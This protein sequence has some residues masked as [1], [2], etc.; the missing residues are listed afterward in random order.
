MID[1]RINVRGIIFKDGK[2]FAQQLTPGIDGQAR[3]YWCTPGGGLE[4]NEPLIDGVRR[5]ILEETGVDAKIGKLLFVEQFRDSYNRENLEFFF[6]IE[7]ADDFENIDLSKT[8]HGVEEI[9][10][11]DFINPKENDLKPDFLKD[12]DF[13]DYI[14]NAKTVLIDCEFQ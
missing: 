9:R 5:E 14:D 12:I 11:F 8:S 1:R 7:N 2:V 10:N 13:Q 3:N 6:H 4:E